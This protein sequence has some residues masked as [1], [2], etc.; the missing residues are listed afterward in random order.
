MSEKNNVKN[1]GYYSITCV[2][3]GEKIHAMYVAICCFCC[4]F[5]CYVMSDSCDPMD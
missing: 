3:L 2:K 4:S 1:R 5:S